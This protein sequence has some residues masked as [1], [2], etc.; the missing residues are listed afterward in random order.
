M[1]KAIVQSFLNEGARVTATWYRNR[2]SGKLHENLRWLHLDLGDPESIRELILN[3]EKT[4]GVV[5][6]F[7]HNAVAWPNNL[8]GGRQSVL[9][10][11]VKIN[12]EGTYLLTDALLERMS[13]SG[14]GRIVLLSS[15][16]AEDGMPGSA[17][18]SG[19]KAALHGMIRGW[20]W[21]A[22]KAGVLVNG[23]LP[24]LTLTKRVREKVPREVRDQVQKQT[25]T[26]KLSDPEDIASMAVYIG[27]AANRNITG[28]LIRVDGGL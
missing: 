13:N 8:E 5:Q 17:L 7:I 24:G 9:R 25:P 18:Y 23:I 1:G 10:D 3:S 12:V 21:D 16:L 19:I 20:M 22:G 4:F 14:W 27:S 6:V 28:S 2:P 15:G 26:Q 11:A